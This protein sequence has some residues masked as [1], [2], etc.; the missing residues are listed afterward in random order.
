MKPD[1]RVT[2]KKFQDEAIE[3]SLKMQERDLDEI[4]IYIK[5][6]INNYTRE[7]LKH[8]NLSV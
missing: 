4:K 1:S 6:Y 5:F 3:K 7:D 2:R 8:V